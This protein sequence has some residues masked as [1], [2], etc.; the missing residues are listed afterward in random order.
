[1]M[2]DVKLKCLPG[3]RELKNGSRLHFHH[4]AGVSVCKLV[5]LDREVLLP[6][7]EGYAQ[8]RFTESVFLRNGDRFV[9]RFFSPVETVGGGAVLNSCPRRHKR[10]RAEVL[11]G[12]K[13]LDGGTEQEKLLR[14]FRELGPDPADPED[15][16]GQTDLPRQEFEEMLTRLIAEEK[17]I[18][19]GERAVLHRDH[20]DA[21]GE[22]LTALLADFHNREPMQPGMKRE[23]LRSRLTPRWETGPANR[24]LDILSRRG[25]AEEENQRFRLPG[26]RAA[27]TPAQ[28]RLMEA[29]EADFL[30]S[31]L[32]FSCTA[33]GVKEKYA[34][35]KELKGA[36]DALFQSGRLTA[37]SPQ[38]ALH[39]SLYREVWKQLED[40]CRENGGITLGQFRDLTG[41]SRKYALLILESFDR[42]G[43]T[44]KTGEMRILTE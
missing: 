12:L 43:L 39:E 1:M 29:I 28:E 8:L 9:V 23:E 31:G 25:L 11:E 22:R 44:R 35:K 16:Y 21:L 26:F 34:G 17:L 7:E 18:S 33:D 3:A 13:V 36:L 41:T 32:T 4:G 10:F 40:F 20:L 24:A 14:C 6:G 15:L 30:R 38:T 27:F 2:L 37:L 5:L 19:L 42:K